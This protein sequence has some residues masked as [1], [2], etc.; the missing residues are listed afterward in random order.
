M[1]CRQHDAHP[2]R[3]HCPTWLRPMRRALATGQSCAT[4]RQHRAGWGR[5]RGC[6]QGGTRSKCSTYATAA[7]AKKSFQPSGVH[8]GRGAGAG[9]GR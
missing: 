2:R 1:S 3:R 9:G 5:R 4:Q 7:R 8:K 6:L